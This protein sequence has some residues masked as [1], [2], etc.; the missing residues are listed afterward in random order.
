M[1][2]IRDAIENIVTHP[3]CTIL[4]IIGIIDCMVQTVTNRTVR[5]IYTILSALFGG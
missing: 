5:P 2:D 3:A 1:R 4:A